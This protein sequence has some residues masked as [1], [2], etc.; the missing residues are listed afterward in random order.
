M[1]KEIA[2]SEVGELLSLA[3]I[4]LNGQNPWDVKVYDDHFYAAVL[5]NGSIGAGEAY[6]KKWWDCPRL[7]ELFSR[8]LTTS[9]EER[10]KKSW[11]TVFLSKIIN[12]QSQSRAFYISERHYDL[13]NELFR[14]MLDKRMVYTCAYWKN[15]TTLDDAQEQKLDLT[16]RKL[17]LKPGDH[18][19]DIGCG[20]GSFAKFAAENYGAKV[21]GVTVSAEQAQLGREQCKDLPVDIKLMDYRQLEGKFDHIVSLGMFEHVG[22]KNYS[23]FMK[24]V[25]RCLKED[26]LFLLHTI[27]SNTS[28]TWTDPWIDKYIF[29][30]SMLPS[31]QQIGKAI[32]GNFVM[33]DWHNFS[34]DYDQTLLAWHANFEKHWST[35]KE[36]YDE[37]FHRMWDYYLLTSA[38]SFR[39]RK[40]QLWQIVLSKNGVR[41]GYDS[42]R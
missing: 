36:K 6:M 39:A 40:N 17:N 34:A 13:G 37:K 2:K 27:G 15:A 16:C 19:L 4:A 24:A 3:G 38:G 21:T 35:L 20:W 25:N 5:S 12:R 30:G 8:I 31:I 1:F 41:G 28:S 11:R 26:G 22:Y 23:T 10:I 7:D 9:F 29:P 14:Q 42:V 18:V 32:E 33:E